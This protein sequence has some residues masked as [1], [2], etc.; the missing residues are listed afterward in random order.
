M[1]QRTPSADVA[2][3]PDWSGQTCAVVASGPSS[4]QERVD[5]LRDR[6][7]VIVVNNTHELAPWA[8]VLYAADERWWVVRRPYWQKFEGLKV[9]QSASAARNNGLHLVHLLDP[10]DDRMNLAPRGLIGRGGNSGFQAVNLALQFGARKILLLGLDFCGENWH[11]RHRDGLRNRAHKGT[12][13]KWAKVFDCQADI[14]AS[15]GVA[16]VNCS[17][18][19]ILQ[20]YPKASI[21]DALRDV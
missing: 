21:E 4:T 2:W 11:G 17:P 6:C 7:R 20:R 19:S 16:V 1:L 18:C 5:Q 15:L 13:G 12:L 9:T 8:D 3:F 14:L 10:R